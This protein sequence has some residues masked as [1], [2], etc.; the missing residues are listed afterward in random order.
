[1]Q[2]DKQDPIIMSLNERLEKL[3]ILR[4]RLV[5]GRT[6]GVVLVLIPERLP[7][8]ETSRALGQLDEAGVKV[9]ALVVNR[10]LPASS[11]DPFLSARQRQE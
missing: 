11:S 10:V 1:D 7:I 5:S 6:T 9:G 4:A 2:D 8:E 3:R